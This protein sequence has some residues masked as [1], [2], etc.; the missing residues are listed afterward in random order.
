MPQAGLK[1]VGQVSTDPDRE[2]W[3][4]QAGQGATPLS[5][6]PGLPALPRAGSWLVHMCNPCLL[7]KS[8]AGDLH[9]PFCWLPSFHRTRASTFQ[10]GEQKFHEDI[11]LTSMP[12][13]SRGRHGKSTHRQNGW[14]QRASRKKLRE[15]NRSP[16]T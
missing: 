4:P 9:K 8:P 13:L 6:R 14:A 5:H 7:H 16:R 12:Y 2:P 3:G 1:A 15:Q 11:C 10:P